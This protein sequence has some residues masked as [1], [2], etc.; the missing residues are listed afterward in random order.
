MDGMVTVE[1]Q[2]SRNGQQWRYIVDIPEL[3]GLIRQLD[4][5][6]TPKTPVASAP[7][8]TGTVKSE[9]MAADG[10]AV[11]SDASAPEDASEPT[12]PAAMQNANGH[13]QN[14]ATTASIPE[15][16]DASPL[17]PQAE[18][19]DSTD[20]THDEP[21]EASTTAGSMLANL[22]TPTDDFAMSAPAPETP[23]ISPAAEETDTPPD[24]PEDDIGEN[25][26]ATSES[27]SP[28]SVDAS[29]KETTETGVYADVGSNTEAEMA[30]MGS[31]METE[32]AALGSTMEIPMGAAGATEGFDYGDALNIEAPSSGGW[33]PNAMTMPALSWGAD[34]EAGPGAP[35]SEPALD[36][37]VHL[38]PVQSLSAPAAASTQEEPPI[39]A[40]ETG[41]LGM[42]PLIKWGLILFGLALLTGG[43]YFGAMTILGSTEVPPTETQSAPA[44]PT[45]QPAELP[46]TKP[47]AAPPQD[48]P[49]VFMVVDPRNQVEPERKG[50]RG[51]ELDALLRPLTN[52]ERRR[53]AREE[54]ARKAQERIAAKRAGTKPSKKDE[55]TKAVATAP[56]NKPIE[57]ATDALELKDSSRPIEPQSY[58]DL[59]QAARKAQKGRRYQEAI[60]YYKKAAL[61]NP[62]SVEPVAKLGWAYLASGNPTQAILK[63]SEAKRKNPAYRDT[64]VGLAKSLERAGRK[65]DAITVYKQYLRMCPN[66]RKAKG[67]RASLMRL[68]ADI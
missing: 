11:S 32:M 13:E 51:I 28:P 68:G 8:E 12:S 20:I 17:E 9:P 27:A 15:P 44:A 25:A 29:E 33:D 55:K 3:A 53:L 65:D 18:P 57:K 52:A 36:P 60:G 54:K 26:S 10:P 37:E 23:P 46:P 21:S 59:M 40:D 61:R 45:A 49:I 66:C 48:A 6:R 67:V 1:D 30:A 39:T 35:P 31:T 34:A 2:I 5:S 62:K 42:N 64:Y 50:R 63:F 24:L 38:Q 16:A 41:S 7:A 19:V 56:A 4:E 43:A 58:D 22:E 14:G 47:V